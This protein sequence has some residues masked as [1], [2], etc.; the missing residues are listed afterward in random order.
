ML[1]AVIDAINMVVVDVLSDFTPGGGRVDAVVV[2]DQVEVV[3]GI[4]DV[5]DVAVTKVLEPVRVVVETDVVVSEGVT[6]VVTDREFQSQ[7]SIFQYRKKSVGLSCLLGNGTEFER[8][9]T[10]LIRATPRVARTVGTSAVMSLGS[11]RYVSI[12][13]DITISYTEFPPI[14]M[15]LI[16]G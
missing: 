8:V 10:L 7:Q 1:P 9:N 4:G 14:D 15:G 3:V 11:N 12:L 2:L 13:H 6:V 5:T 16:C